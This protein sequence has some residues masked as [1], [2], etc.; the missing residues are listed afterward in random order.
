MDVRGLTRTFRRPGRPD[1]IALDAVELAVTV[2]TTHGLLGPNGAGKTTLCKILSTVLLPTSGE[3]RVLGHDA[4]RDPRAVRSQIGIA[5]GGERG[6]YGRLT[7]EQNL[8]YWAALLGL[9]GRQARSRVALTMERFGL[10]DRARDRVETLSRG[11]KQRVH[12]ARAVLGE[13]Q[14]LILDEPTA[15]LDPVAARAVR[16]IVSDELA[17]TCTVLLTTHDLREAE[18]L[19]STVTVMG[20]GRVLAAGNPAELA[21]TDRPTHTVVLATPAPAVVERLCASV[22]ATAVEVSSGRT[23]LRFTSS[24]DL[25]Q[26]IAVLLSD[27]VVGFTVGE[28]SLEDYYV[29]LVGSRGVGE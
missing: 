10:R 29:D 4:A 19:C 11:W 17:G 6:L 15:G 27:G 21:L 5:F 24:T 22:R 23:E 26:G 3:V 1:R 2:G 9:G 12:L 28:G 16:Q 25:Q 14:L 8:R 13:P 20:G 7:V 18:L